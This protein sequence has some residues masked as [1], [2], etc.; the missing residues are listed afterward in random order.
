MQKGCTVSQIRI[1]TGIS[2]VTDTPPHYK[3]FVDAASTPEAF[4]RDNR[5]GGSEYNALRDL[6][7]EMMQK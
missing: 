5:I 4:R 7:W 1:K 2:E 6:L 3:F